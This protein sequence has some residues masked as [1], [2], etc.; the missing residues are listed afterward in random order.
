MMWYCPWTL[1]CSILLRVAKRWLYCRYF[2]VRNLSLT[3]KPRYLEALC[4]SDR[5]E[6]MNLDPWFSPAL[7]LTRLTCVYRWMCVWFF[8]ADFAETLL[9]VHQRCR[10]CREVL[11][12]PSLQD[13]HLC[14]IR[15]PWWL[16]NTLES[17]YKEMD[18]K[19][20]WLAQ[21]NVRLMIPGLWLK[22]YFGCRD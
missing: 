6:K 9:L 7:L 8:L 21:W 12:W 19:D 10:S 18:V 4:S 17:L 16:V 5:S 22:P 3:G 20:A 13:L 14:D 2:I 15:G 11:L 1:S